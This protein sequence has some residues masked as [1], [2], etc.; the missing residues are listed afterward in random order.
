MNRSE[1]SD[2]VLSVLVFLRS[3][4]GPLHSDQLEDGGFDLKQFFKIYKNMKLSEFIILKDWLEYRDTRHLKKEVE[5]FSKEKLDAFIA[6]ER[7]SWWIP[8]RRI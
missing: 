4:R 7:R 2:D 1:G 5:V 6:S 8:R 3:Q